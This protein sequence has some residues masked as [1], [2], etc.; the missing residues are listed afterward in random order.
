MRAA[1]SIQSPKMLGLSGIGNVKLLKAH[2]IEVL[3]GNPNMGENLQ[4]HL[5]CNLSFEEYSDA[6]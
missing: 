2:G 4:D 5:L 6:R 1:G 3:I